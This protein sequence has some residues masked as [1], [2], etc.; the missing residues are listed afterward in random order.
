MYTKKGIFFQISEVYAY[1][2]IEVSLR[3][4]AMGPTR[5]GGGAH[6]VGPM[7]QPH[8]YHRSRVTHA[9][10]ILTLKALSVPTLLWAAKGNP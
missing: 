2:C 8:G 7:S 5:P 6:Q 1:V 4:V 3:G 9:G 10:K